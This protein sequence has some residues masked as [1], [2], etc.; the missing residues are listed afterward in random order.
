MIIQERSKEQTKFHQK[1]A[2]IELKSLWKTLKYVNNKIYVGDKLNEDRL[3][4][5]T[6]IEQIQDH[7]W[8]DCKDA[9]EL[10][11]IMQEGKMVPGFLHLE[12]VK[13]LSGLESL[14]VKG[15]STSNLDSI[16]SEIFDF[17]L[18]LYSNQDT[19]SD[20]TIADFLNSIPSLPRVWE[21]TDELTFDIS[22]DEIETAIKQ[23]CP[24]KSLGCDGLT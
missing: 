8:F 12:D 21:N 5:E 3:L 9:Q 24:R 18:D 23:L 16:L 20:A 4:L 19:V 14:L 7:A 17:Y 22:A 13:L 6:R 15:K 10:T 11:W 2:W 1:H